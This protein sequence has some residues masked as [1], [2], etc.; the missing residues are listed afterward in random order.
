MYRLLYLLIFLL[1]ISTYPQKSLSILNKPK[2]THFSRSDF[3]ADTQFWTMTEDNEGIKYFGNNDGVLIFDGEQWKRVMLPNH[4]SVRSLMTT[5]DGQVLA[6]GYNELG[7]IEK[8]STGSYHFRSMVQELKLDDQKLENLW[9]VHEFKNRIIYRSF[10]ELIVIAEKTATHIS[11][12][13]SFTHSDVV[14]N[15]FMVQDAGQG[16]FSFDPENMQLLKLFSEEDIQG[17]EIVSFLPH[18]QINEILCVAKDG[19]IFK[20]NLKNGQ[21]QIWSNAFKDT[22]QDQIISAIYHQGSYLLGTLASK[23]IS[24]NKEGEIENNTIRYSEMS[25]SSILGLYQTGE[26]IWALLN[27]GLDFIEFSSP[28]SNIFSQAS[29]Y[30]I[31]I[32]DEKITLATNKGVYQMNLSETNNSEFKNI[33]GL[34]GQAWQIQEVN[35]SILVSHDRGLFELMPDGPKK[36]G[37]V[38]GFWKVS[39]IPG[40]PNKYLAAN[41]N[42]LYPLIYENETWILKDKVPG[43]NESSRDLL[44]AIEPNTYWVCHGYKGVYRIKFN[45]DYSRVYGL[46]QYTNQNGLISPFNVNVKNW[47]NNVVFTTNTGIYEFN[48]EENQFV[49]Y[50]PLN[51]ILDT[52]RN[53][54]TIQ[55]ADKNVF[56]VQD[57]EIGY[58]NKEKEEP[59]INSKLFLNLKG[60]LNRGMESIY[61]LSDT[62]VLVGATTGLY[63]YNLPNSAPKKTVQTEI[64]KISYT[65]KQEAK[66]LGLNG[67]ENILPVKTELLRFEFSTPNMP[68]SSEVEYQ[69]YLEGIEQQKSP[70]ISQS[71]KE[72]THLPPGSYTFNVK[73]RN[74]LGLEGDWASI[75]FEIPPVWYRTRVAYLFYI[76]GFFGLIILLF[77]L[78]KRKIESERLRSKSASEKAQ[79]L[80]KLEIE[81]LKL[82]QDKE[83]IRR[84]KMM[85]QEDVL[86]KS[87][88][89]ANYTIMLVKK[90]E[91]FTDT[92]E[93]LQEFKRGLKTQT[94]RKRLQKVLNNLNQH[95]IGE[96]YM[97]VFDVNFEKVHHNF[98]E[99]LKEIYPG[100]TQRDLRLCAFVKMN[101][102]NKEIAPLLNISVRGVETAR[103]RIRK[104]LNV[105]DANFAI[106]LDNLNS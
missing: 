80:L 30:D 64:T 97:K 55:I 35:N 8:D 26:N 50:K 98:F 103:Y 52:T 62:T 94:A 3:K 44:P 6:G 24:L 54:R 82:K 60:S 59:E 53:T 56:V 22:R 1:S 89:L 63:H 49:P 42:G 96:E 28:V 87:K 70:W 100:I 78:I 29:V 17:K 84:D 86:Y 10:N 21:M 15:T 92:F 2:I 5:S 105:D 104:K 51:K 67:N 13:Q 72:Y 14:Q 7:L 46:D 32:R 74:L 99:E 106:F 91:V 65:E 95:R 33:S 102:T 43:F 41:Y 81:Q 57:D 40:E 27:N 85:L 9:Q 37:N 39:A 73:S 66:L 79:R 77:F 68:P 12:N 23:L 47:E 93:N 36:I 88:E 34:E 18:E 101:L 11:S 83:R 31:L 71:F 48:R 75:S 45:E 19:T 61:P 4:S 25:D 76:I 69:Y 38:N 16:I 90:K 20:G 58:Y